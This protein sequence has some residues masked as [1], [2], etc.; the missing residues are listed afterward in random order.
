[1]QVGISHLIAPDLPLAEFFHQAAQSGYE[2]AEIII[3]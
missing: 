2:V 3:C 1:M